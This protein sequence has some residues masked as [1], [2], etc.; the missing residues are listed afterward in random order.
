VVEEE[1]VVV[2]VEEMDHRL[3]AHSYTPS[4]IPLSKNLKNVRRCWQGPAYPCPSARTCTRW[5]LGP[6]QAVARASAQQPARWAWRVSL[7]PRPIR[8][9]APIQPSPPRGETRPSKKR[10]ASPPFRVPL[11]LLDKALRRWEIFLLGRWGRFRGNRRPPLPGA[12]R[13]DPRSRPL[14]RSRTR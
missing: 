11:L 6:L 12:C 7:P 4:R 10:N 1:E 3:H 5:I 13:P 9:L 14:R 2:V 8:Q